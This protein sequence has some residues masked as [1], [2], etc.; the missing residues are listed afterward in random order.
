MNG[1]PAASP[2][3]GTFRRGRTGKDDDI[4]SPSLGGSIDSEEM[5]SAS[6]VSTE[7]TQDKLKPASRRSSDDKRS[8]REGSRLSMLIPKKLKHRR[9]SVQVEDEE[10]KRLSPHPS[11]DTGASAAGR[12]VRNA[13]D[14]SLGHTDS[15]HSSLMTEDSEQEG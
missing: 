15:M 8:I 3:P 6:R 10:D 7:S 12:G 5:L 13:S 11:P 14:L 4:P 2:K 1:T 9:K